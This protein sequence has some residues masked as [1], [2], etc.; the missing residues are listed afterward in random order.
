[1]TRPCRN[2]GGWSAALHS[3]LVSNIR[4]LE[5][6]SLGMDRRSE[7]VEHPFEGV[8]SEYQFEALGRFSGEV[9]QAGAY[10]GADIPDLYSRVDDWHA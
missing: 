7:A 1:M 6:E 2:S 8:V 5:H 4:T 3:T 9:L 10:G